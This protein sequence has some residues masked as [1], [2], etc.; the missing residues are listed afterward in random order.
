MEGVGEHLSMV[1]DWVKMLRIAANSFLEHKTI[2]HRGDVDTCVPQCWS[3]PWVLQNLIALS[4]GEDI[5]FDLHER[6]G[7]PQDLSRK[8]TPFT[9]GILFPGLGL[10]HRVRCRAER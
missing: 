4:Q 10:S 7:S 2:V 3:G 6:V 8:L 1:S 9:V 5:P